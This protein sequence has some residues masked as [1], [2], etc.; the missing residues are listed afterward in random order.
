MFMLVKCPEF[1]IKKQNN[2]EKMKQ[3]WGM[4]Y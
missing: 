4:F 2:Y 3:K 1:K